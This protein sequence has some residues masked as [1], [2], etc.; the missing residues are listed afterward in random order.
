MAIGTWTNS[1]GNNSAMKNKI[2][3]QKY[4]VGIPPKETTTTAKVR[5]KLLVEVKAE[6][7]YELKQKQKI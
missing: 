1:N 3:A 7:Y 4:G 5:P 6:T 2:T